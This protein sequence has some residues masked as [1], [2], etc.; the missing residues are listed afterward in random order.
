MSN[1]KIFITFGG[2]DNKYIYAAKRLIKPTKY[3]YN[4]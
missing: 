4:I 2:G 3:K 1:T